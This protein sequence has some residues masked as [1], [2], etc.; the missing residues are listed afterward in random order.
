MNIAVLVSA[1]LLLAVVY[2]PGLQGIFETETLGIEHWQ[3]ILPLCLLPAVAA[4]ITKW[5]LLRNLERK[6]AEANA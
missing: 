1:T 2:I 5:F 6:H 4:E 3:Y